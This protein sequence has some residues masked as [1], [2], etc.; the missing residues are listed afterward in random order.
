MLLLVLPMIIYF[1]VLY[2]AYFLSAFAWSLYATFIVRFLLLLLLFY[3]NLWV[4]DAL[5]HVACFFFDFMIADA[6]RTKGWLANRIREP[7]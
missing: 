1:A 3:I 5:F 7:K 2:D 4:L 6:N